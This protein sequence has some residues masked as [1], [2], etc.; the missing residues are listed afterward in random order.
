M[1]SDFRVSGISPK[2]GLRPV[3]PGVSPHFCQIFGIFDEFSKLF[4]GC[5]VLHFEKLS[6]M[7]KIW[8]K[9]KKVLIRLAL[10]PFLHGSGTKDTQPETRVSGTSS[11]T[12]RNV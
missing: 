7:P 9:M 11:T 5:G 4:S 12:S 8:Q 3:K 2:M 10:N 1:K 6:N